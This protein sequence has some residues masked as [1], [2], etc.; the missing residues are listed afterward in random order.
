MKEVTS[1]N[2]IQLLNGSI[3][4]TPETLDV[5]SFLRFLAPYHRREKEPNV[6]MDPEGNVAWKFLARNLHINANGSLTI[7][8]GASRKEH[9]EENLVQTLNI[10]NRFIRRPCS[11][12][13]EVSINNSI[14]Y[15]KIVTFGRGTI[16]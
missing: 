1:D 10:L 2:R 11:W 5:H 16:L 4:F 14:K 7:Q 13:F 3:T 12:P 8:L 15:R 9:T 6:N